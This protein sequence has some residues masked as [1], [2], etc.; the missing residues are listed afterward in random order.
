MPRNSHVQYYV[1][2]KRAK[3]LK[4]PF[5]TI[6]M[7]RWQ[8][9]EFVKQTVDAYPEGDPLRKDPAWIGGTLEQIMRDPNVDRVDVARGLGVRSD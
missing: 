1:Y 4:G 7:P 5:Q 2:N 6:A 3:I 8:H 9:D